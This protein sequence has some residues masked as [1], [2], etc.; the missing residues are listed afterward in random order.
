V[1]HRCFSPASA[2]ASRLRPASELEM[3]WAHSMPGFLA[4]KA[5]E[6]QGGPAAH[7]AM[8]DRIQRAHIVETRNVA[9]FGVL[10]ECAR[11]VG[12]DLVRWERDVRAPE[13]RAAVEADLAEAGRLGIRAAPALVFG[14]RRRV[15]GAVPEGVLRQ[16]IDDLLT[17]RALGRA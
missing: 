5:A 7:W 12:L 3:L 10:R 2:A 14:D 8:F 15:R 4:C 6:F 16:I 11:D 13:A 17:G 1:E 9:D